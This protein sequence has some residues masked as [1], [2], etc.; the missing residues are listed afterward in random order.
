MVEKVR[1]PNGYFFF[2]FLVKQVKFHKILDKEFKLYI[3]I[4]IRILSH[5]ST[6]LVVFGLNNGRAATCGDDFESKFE[7]YK[8][9]KNLPDCLKC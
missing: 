9:D 6:M 3:I 2:D 5:E 1:N 8:N 4:E 7:F